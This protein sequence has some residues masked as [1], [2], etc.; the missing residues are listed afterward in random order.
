M[1]ELVCWYECV[2]RDFT[3]TN[4]SNDWLIPLPATSRSL[5]HSTV[6]VEVFSVRGSQFS[7]KGFF[8]WV[9]VATLFFLVP[10][11]P[12][13]G[14]HFDDCPLS[15]TDVS[16]ATPARLIH[17]C[18]ES[19]HFLEGLWM[20][21]TRKSDPGNVSNG[22]NYETHSFDYFVERL[23]ALFTVHVFEILCGSHEKPVDLR[24]ALRGP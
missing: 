21:N 14:C 16:A 13:F 11:A 4:D 22:I 17:V 5:T 20:S 3:N 10:V 15:L 8:W 1:L 19:K 9:F 6:V 23:R 18:C 2:V 24:L 12:R 7:V